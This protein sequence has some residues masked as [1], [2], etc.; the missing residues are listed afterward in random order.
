MYRYGLLGRS[1]EHSYSPLVH[2]A[3]GQYGYTLLDKDEDYAIDLLRRGKFFGINVTHPYKES[4]VAYCDEL[5]SSARRLGNV[6][7]I[8]RREDGSLYGDNTDVYGFHYL[9]RRSG[10]EVSAKKAV[11]FGGGGA[12]KTAKAVLLAMGA[13]EATLIRRSKS[14]T[15]DDLPAFADAEIIVNATPVGMYPDNGASPVDLTVFSHPE[16]VFDLVYNPAYTALLLQ[17]EKL[18]IAGFGGLTMLVAQAKHAAELF[19]A[20][21]LP[22]R[23]IPEVVKATLAVKRNI[24]LIGMPGCGKSIVASAL[25]RALNR[26]CH[27]SDAA[28]EAATGRRITNLINRDE[29]SFRRR[30]SRYLAGVGKESGVII[31]AGDGAVTRRENYDS[32]HQNGIILWLRR[33]NDDA[34]FERGTYSVEDAAAMHRNRAPLYEEF[35]DII[36]ENEGGV[37]ATVE[38]IIEVLGVRP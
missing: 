7:T 27:D 4:I 11:I 23:L 19:T 31:A 14:P 21:K 16:A 36:I 32:L 35:A 3:L 9:V 12:A 26:P 28:I 2:R 15:Y 1:L 5:S 10:V 30:E 33:P 6:N 25:S 18:G 20:E 17:C 38:E 13:A 34:V 37:T 22:N 8:V 24:C 29:E